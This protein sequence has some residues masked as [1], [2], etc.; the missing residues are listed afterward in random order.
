MHASPV[1]YCCSS[2]F[3]LLY[4]QC[5]PFFVLLP[6]AYNH[7]FFHLNTTHTW[8]FLSLAITLYCFPPFKQNPLK[9]VL[10]FTVCNFFLISFWTHFGQAFAFTTS[11]KLLLWMICMLLNLMVSFQSSWNLT[12]SSIWQSRS[13][14]PPWNNMLFIWLPR[15]QTFLI[16][17]LLH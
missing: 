10:V 5:F 1:T 14:P 12:L 6:L 2:I 8:L 15:Y 7:C 9:V 3:P 11:V 4:Y 17:L 13:P 16:L